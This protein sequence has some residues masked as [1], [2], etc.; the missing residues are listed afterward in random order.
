M[1]ETNA[2]GNFGD[3]FNHITIDDGEISSITHN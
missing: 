3:G 2:K 1:I